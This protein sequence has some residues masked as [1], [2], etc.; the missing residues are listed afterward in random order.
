MKGTGPVLALLGIL[1]LSGCCKFEQ[2]RINDIAVGMTREQVESRLCQPEWTSAEGSTETLHYKAQ[3]GE[4][5]FVRLKNGVVE[6]FGRGA[7][8]LRM[9]RQGQREPAVRVTI[10]D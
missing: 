6:A 5:F 8:L 1:A 3:S 9:Q 7:E 2:K 4:R 10:K